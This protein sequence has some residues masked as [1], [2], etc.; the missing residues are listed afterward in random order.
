MSLLANYLAEQTNSDLETVRSF[1]VWIASNIVYDLKSFRNNTYPDQDAEAVLAH[2]T[3]LCSG[4]ANLF[5][6][7][8]Q[9]RGITA[10]IISGYSKGY[11]YKP[12]KEFIVSDHSWNAVRLNGVWYLI[13]VTWAS[14]QNN[15]NNRS[16]AGPLFNDD[17]FLTPPNKFVEDHL[18]L[19]PV[20]QLMNTPV[21]LDVYEQNSQAI[22]KYLAQ[23][24]SHINYQD[25]L[26]HWKESSQSDIDSHRRS[27][28]FNPKNKRAVFRL[29]YDLLLEAGDLIDS[30]HDIPW[31][32]FDS[33]AAE[34]KV[35]IF[36]FLDEAAFHFSNIPKGNEDYRSAQTLLEETTYQKG[37]YY[38]E[39]GQRVYDLFV[40]LDKATFYANLPEGIELIDKYYDLA[41]HYFMLVDQQS[42]YYEESMRYINDY[43]KGKNPLNPGH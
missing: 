1:Y 40:P 39:L 21:P 18:P 34:R 2:R 25:S 30:V 23:P 29:G 5:F 17:Y 35:K 31:S 28:A 43:M 11:G 22:E 15:L 26:S 3:G 32:E 41:T 42:R 9:E 36:A 13:D 19:D 12:G 14:N 37:V 27:I 24:T 6:Q 8:C 33:I 16:V 20:W 10:T 7:L 38:Y 4:Y